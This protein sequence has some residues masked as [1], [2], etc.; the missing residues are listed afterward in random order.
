MTNWTP[1]LNHRA[2]PRY[3]A[4]ADALAA[5]VSAGRFKPG[6]RLPTHRDLAWR[7]GVTIGTVSRAYAEAERRGLVTGEVGRG[8]YVRAAVNAVDQMMPV[9]PPGEQGLID[10]TFAF[11]PAGGAEAELGPALRTLADDPGS[12]VLL[13]YQPNAGRRGHRAAGAAW[14]AAGGLEVAPER[15]VV[16]A[17]AQHGVLAALATLT[18]PGDRIVTEAVTYPGI[19]LVARM[20]G[21]RM[22][23]LAMDAHGLLPDALEAACKT[24]DVKALYCIP[25]LQNPTTATLP[26]ERRRAIANIAA[27]HRLA[28]VED[29]IM[30]RLSDDTSTPIAGL[31]PDLTTYVTSLSKTV[32]PGLRMG[33]LAGPEGTTERLAA[34]VRTTCWMT[35]PLTAEIGARWIRDG[36]A[37]RIRDA[38][39]REALGR[40]Q[41]AL[42]ILGGW[43]VVSAPASLHLWLHLPEPWRANDFVAEARQRGAAISSAEVFA[44]GRR[45]LPHA[46]R[47]CF[48]APPDR[49][50]LEQGLRALADLLE[51]GPSQALG[52]AVV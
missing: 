20:L 50:S 18:R 44:V 8:T 6:D 26:E 9:E 11:P 2:G 43:E 41:L 27:R 22:E 15:I 29:D 25:T 40:R 48:C 7:L 5:D 30:R 32:A 47:V 14:L 35:T 39:R 34:A 16:T 17:G 49:E 23:G 19:K 42:D 4:I 3:V 33:F 45:D 37:E 52:A 24:N 28:I 21:L 46:V 31:A 38:R 36:T 1:D 13:D 12:A 10:F 51:D